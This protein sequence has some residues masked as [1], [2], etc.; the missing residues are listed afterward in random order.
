MCGGVRFVS[1]NKEIKTYFPNPQ[2]QLPILLKD[3]SV[4]LQPWGRREQQQ[5]RLPLGGWARHESILAGKWD[6]TNPKPVKIAVE[7]FMEKDNNKVSHW[8]NV[9]SGTYIQGLLAR[10]D[11]ECRIYVVTIEPDFKVIH[12][13]YPRIVE[14]RIF[15]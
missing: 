13:R 8:F 10:L 2:A 11:D 6:Y 12:S 14:N 9:E 4:T 1:N 3:Y 5:G 15:D 7:A